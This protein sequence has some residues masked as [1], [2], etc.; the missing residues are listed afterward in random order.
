MDSNIDGKDCLKKSVDSSSLSLPRAAIGFFSNIAANLFGSLGS[1]SLL[2]TS[3]HVQYCQPRSKMPSEMEVLELCNLCTAEQPLQ[4]GDF[5]T[6]AE[7]NSEQKVEETQKRED[8]LSPSGSKS[9]EIFLKFDMISDC[10][11]HHFINGSGKNLTS[12][13]VNYISSP[14]CHLNLT[15]KHVERGVVISFFPFLLLIPYR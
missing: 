8:F 10:S 5:E 13:Q 3:G 7:R 9:P 2:S 6:F 12:S 14:L 4:A 1:T 15:G 11:D